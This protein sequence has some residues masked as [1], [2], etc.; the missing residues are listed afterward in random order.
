MG[1][2]VNPKTQA[3]LKLLELRGKTAKAA[4]VDPGMVAGGGGDPAAAGM[5]PDAAAAPPPGP[6]PAIADL[7][8][9]VDALASQ[10]SSMGGAAGGAAGANTL[11]PKVDVN[12]T[13]LQILKITTLL[14]EAAGIQ[15]PPSAMVPTSEG[16]S[17][18]ASMSQ[19]GDFS[20][21]SQ[22][23]GGAISPIEPMQGALPPP[24]SGEKASQEQMSLK[25]RFLVASELAKMIGNGES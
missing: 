8:A 9:K 22:S 7:S 15:V 18:L 20:G 16:L 2:A 1:T 6:D 5:P 14:A 10:F 4:F 24:P 21:V 12:V 19:S 25:D 23:G 11:K 17:Q 3:M 13:L